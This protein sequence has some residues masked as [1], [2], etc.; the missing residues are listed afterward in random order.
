MIIY[1]INICLSVSYLKGK[2]FLVDDTFYMRVVFMLFCP[3]PLDNDD[4]CGELISQT[5]RMN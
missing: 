4:L 2:D 5:K 3:S 1:N